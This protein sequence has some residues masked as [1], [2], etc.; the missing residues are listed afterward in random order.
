[1]S[2]HPRRGEHSPLHCV[3][4]HLDYGVGGPHKTTTLF[5]VVAATAE[6]TSGVELD[7]RFL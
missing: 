5:T 7:L 4:F 6:P 2:A 3:T 1:M